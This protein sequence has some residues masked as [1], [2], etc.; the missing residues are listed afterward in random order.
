MDNAAPTV[1]A[2][3][4]EPLEV[5]SEDP[6]HQTYCETFTMNLLPR[7]DEAGHVAAEFRLN[8][9]GWHNFYGWPD[10]PPGTPFKFTPRGTNIKEII[11][12]ALSPGGMVWAPFE[13]REAGYG[14]HKVEYRAIDAAGNISEASSFT[15]TVLPFTAP[16]CAGR[17]PALR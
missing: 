1:E 9:D 7:D 10:A 17:L 8:G 16:E 3:L 4:S 5:A 2:E 13:Q 15:A 12:G 6:L 14:T 11:Y